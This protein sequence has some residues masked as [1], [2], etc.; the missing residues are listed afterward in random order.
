M[1]WF[2]SCRKEERR[3]ADDALSKAAAESELREKGGVE[4]LGRE[5]AA[6]R[7]VHE[8]QVG[9]ELQVC[10]GVIRFP[11]HAHLLILACDSIQCYYNLL[12]LGKRPTLEL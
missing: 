2:H 4:D 8:K 9:V 12:L 10:W 7:K 1:V 5:K 3:R 11:M 6:L